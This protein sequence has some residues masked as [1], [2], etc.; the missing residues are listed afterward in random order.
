MMS[1]SRLASR[2]QFVRVMT[3]QC[4]G[5]RAV[6]SVTDLRVALS[7]HRPPWAVR[8]VT[9]PQRGGEARALMGIL[10]CTALIARCCGVAACTA[11]P[12]ARLGEGRSA[13][14][15]V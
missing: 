2:A 7:S 11:W 14:S 5:A 6:A 3:K 10:R 1:V 9:P 8:G 15:L 13:D 12:L 4:G